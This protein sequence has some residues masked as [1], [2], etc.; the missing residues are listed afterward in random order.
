MKFIQYQAKKENERI[1]TGEKPYACNYCEMKFKSLSPKICHERTHNTYDSSSF[2]IPQKIVNNF[3]CEIAELKNS[4][5]AFSE[6]CQ[7][8]EKTF[9]NFA[10]HN[11]LISQNFIFQNFIFLFLIFLLPAQAKLIKNPYKARI[12]ESN[13]NL[14]LQI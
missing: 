9:Q 11:H 2:L 12:A 10:L 13:I 3:F 8:Y 1:H 6:Y 14:A 7:K 5:Q 4:A